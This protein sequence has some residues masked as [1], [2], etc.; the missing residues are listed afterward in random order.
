MTKAVFMKKYT[1]PTY[2]FYFLTSE[3]DR[4]RNKSFI[5]ALKEHSTEVTTTKNLYTE[6]QSV[7]IY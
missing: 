4:R 5:S 3:I 1:Q 6:Q 2:I 7:G